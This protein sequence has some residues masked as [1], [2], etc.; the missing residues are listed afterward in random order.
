MDYSLMIIPIFHIRLAHSFVRYELKWLLFS[1]SLLSFQRLVWSAIM[2]I[3]SRLPAS[4]RGRKCFDL[5][6]MWNRL[7]PCLPT[8]GLDTNQL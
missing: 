2:L 6:L 4:S 5:R 3:G 7:F 1:I 8:V